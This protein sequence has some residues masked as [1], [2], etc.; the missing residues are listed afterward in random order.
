MSA[1]MKALA[2]RRSPER[3]MIPRTL[4]WA[5]LAL[6]LSA[7]VITSFAVLT[8][9]PRVGQPA[10]GRV[11]AERL[12]I[13]EGRS[14]RAVTVYGFHSLRHSFVSFCIDH[15]IPKAVAVSILGADSDI[16]DQYYTH[17][18]EDAQERA[19]QLISGNG[20]PLKERH[21]RALKYLDSI[22][23]KSAELIAVE[24]LLRG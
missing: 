7:L 5:M 19:I 2:E 4:L 24:R 18:G 6:A 15:N 11:V 9:R 14:A 21:E 13:L 23:Q 20:M 16:I 3:E 10:P 17:I 22:K 12:V 1:T 8:D